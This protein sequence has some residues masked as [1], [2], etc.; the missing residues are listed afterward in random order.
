MPVPKGFTP[1]PPA[2]V[3]TGTPAP[4]DVQLPKG[5]TVDAAEDS[6]QGDDTPHMTSHPEGMWSHLR[7]YLDTSTTPSTE[8]NPIKKGLDD[9]G[10]GVAAST[11]GA[12]NHP[13]QTIE[14]M[15]ASFVAAGVT[16]EGYPMFPYVPGKQGAADRAANEGAQRQAQEQVDQQAQTIKEHPIYAAG[17]FVGPILAT[18]AITGAPG[19]AADLQQRF[20]NPK[21]SF[22][23]PEEAQVREFVKS[24]RLPVG[25][26][27]PTVQNLLGPNGDA[28]SVR[29]VQQWAA[30]RGKPINTP[31]DFAKAANAV[32]SELE[33][34]FKENVLGPYENVK[35]KL[36]PGSSNI[37][38]GE[39]N[40]T[41]LGAIDERLASINKKLILARKAAENG[42][43]SQLAIEPLEA[44]ASV[45][46]NVFYRELANQTKLP[47]DTLV[48]MRRQYG[49]LYS[50]EDA[51]TRA[52]NGQTT[53]AQSIP[54][55]VPEAAI[56]LGHKLTGG[57]EGVFNRGFRRTLPN[58][59]V[60][61]NAPKPA[62]KE[63]PDRG[64]AASDL[65]VL[66]PSIQK[67]AEGVKYAQGKPSATYG[68]EQDI[69]TVAPGSNTITVRDPKRLTPAVKAHEIGH[70]YDANLAPG[71]QAP[72]D[73]P[74]H[75]YMQPKE[76]YQ[77]GPL[78]AAGM[79]MR[80]MPGEKRSQI[81][82][83]YIDYYH[84]P[85]TRKMLQ[86]WVDEYA[87]FPKSNIMPTPQSQ[88]GINTAVRP[89]APPM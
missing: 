27:E 37:G 65:S 73:D 67:V 33:R 28:S 24:L 81:L 17:Q 58:F 72:P 88:A 3:S 38:M 4:P 43:P 51:M 75:P 30:A 36:P 42:N 1:D 12:I 66:P 5:F 87:A 23:P 61:P 53:R 55:S 7:S 85:E 68:G 39:G 76:I 21:S 16:P 82:Q 19:G 57:E 35:V 6:G 64:Y 59:P 11:I 8:T 22:V 44:E 48:Q 83:A 29:V 50:I 32:G 71:Y 13:L 18:H 20:G 78:R 47:A 10:R 46:R 70:V 9:F 62:N 26:I 31:L 63:L 74:N 60:D 69:A 2:T 40:Y 54:R 79:T 49:K 41:S 89:P 52:A 86:P 56:R 34:S 15:G 77:L 45:L 84:D 80:Q 25:E 14:G